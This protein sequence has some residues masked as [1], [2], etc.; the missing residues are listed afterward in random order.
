V[1]GG[2]VLLVEFGGFVSSATVKAGGT[3]LF[4]PG[5]TMSLVTVSKG[6]T[7][8]LVAS[9]PQGVTLAS[10]AILAFASG[11]VLNSNTVSG[12]ST[13]FEVLAGGTDLSA[14]VVSGGTLLVG[15][16]SSSPVALPATLTYRAAAR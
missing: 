15:S 9:I 3:E 2:G 16:R 6:G 10:G 4:E 8:E 13:I 5:G 12:G 11:A 7:L 14:A 1:S